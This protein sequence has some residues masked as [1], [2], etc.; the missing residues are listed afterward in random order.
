[1][2]T[3][4]FL[5]KRKYA[6]NDYISVEIPTV[7]EIIDDEDSYYNLVSILTSSPYDFMVQLDDANI[8]FTSIN[9]YEL[10]LLLFAQLKKKDTHLVFGDLDLSRFVFDENSQNGQV[11]L[12]D[13]STGAKID[14]AI[15]TQIANVLRKIHHLEKNRRKPANEEAKQYLLERARK[16]MKRKNKRASLSFPKYFC[17]LKK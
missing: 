4:N 8:D 2:S 7:G 11:F 12:K 17:V 10:F 9:D 13:K 16:K 3:L 1:M 5:Y 14:R 6:I 15:Y